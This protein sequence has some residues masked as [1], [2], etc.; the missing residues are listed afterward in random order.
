M[1]FRY[2]LNIWKPDNMN[3]GTRQAK[4]KCAQTSTSGTAHFYSYNKIN[5]MQ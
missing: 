3:G 1:Q 2:A 5:W 4:N